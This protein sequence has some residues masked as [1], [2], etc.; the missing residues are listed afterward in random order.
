MKG[1]RE[2]YHDLFKAETANSKKNVSFTLNKPEI[3]EIEHSHY[4]HTHDS[5]SRP[6]KTTSTIA[7]HW[8]EVTWKED[9]NGNLVAE[10]GP[11]IKFN[12]RQTPSGTKKVKGPIKFTKIN[13]MGE[14]VIIEDTHTHKMTYM[15]SELLTQ[16]SAKDKAMSLANEVMSAAAGGVDGF[17]E[18]EANK[19]LSDEGITMR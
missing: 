14:K 18:A 6:Q 17:N 1:S 7:G 12:Y 15:H 19:K 11:P 16:G 10:C 3:V 5:K 13:D 9:A 4:F 2:F 8:H